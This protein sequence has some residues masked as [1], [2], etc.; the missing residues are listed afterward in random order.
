M[1][2]RP[3]RSTLFPYT[4]LFRSARL[5]PIRLRR[6]LGL[7]AEDPA[8]VVE[9]AVA[10]SVVRDGEEDVEAKRRGRPETRLDDPGDVALTAPDREA[11]WG[12]RPVPG[13]GG[14]RAPGR[15]PAAMGVAGST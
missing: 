3:P 1:I 8:R 10:P 4:T 9:V 5:R 12:A 7:E 2:R 6:V 13:G 15:D 14:T 11:A